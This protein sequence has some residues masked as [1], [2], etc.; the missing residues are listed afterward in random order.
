M[1][2]I[3]ALRF[4]RTPHPPRRTSRRA[5]SEAGALRSNST[6]THDN[7]KNHTLR[8]HPLIYIKV[9]TRPLGPAD[10]AGKVIG[11]RGLSAAKTE[12]TIVGGKNFR[13]IG[14]A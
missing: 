12:R 4:F 10:D 3:I 9:S 11:A 6:I 7:T 13:A 2:A 14:S 8:R 1:H 5:S